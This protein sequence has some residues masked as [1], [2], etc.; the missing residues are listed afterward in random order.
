[1]VIEQLLA[2]TSELATTGD[3]ATVTDLR[4]LAVKRGILTGNESGKEL[5]YLGCIFNRAGWINTGQ[6]RRSRLRIT[7]AIKQTIWRRP[8]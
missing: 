3:D 4:E 7:H 1:M 8:V 5:S 6:V 2:L